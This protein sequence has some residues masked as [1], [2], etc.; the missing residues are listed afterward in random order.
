[1]LSNLHADA[2]QT[3]KLWPIPFS[4][5]YLNVITLLYAKVLRKLRPDLRQFF[6]VA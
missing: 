6:R 5:L 1:M 4:P 2:V 3:A